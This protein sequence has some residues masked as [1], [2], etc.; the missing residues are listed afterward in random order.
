MTKR[1]SIW[2]ALSVLALVGL[3]ACGKSEEKKNDVAT[4]PIQPNCAAGTSLVYVNGYPMCQSPTGGYTTPIYQNPIVNGYNYSSD[5]YCYR[6]IQITNSTVAKKFLKE[7][8]GVCD[9]NHSTGGT[10]DCQAWANG[11]FKVNMS[12][13]G[14]QQMVTTIYAY[15]QQTGYWYSLPSFSDFFW[16]MLGF[17]VYNVNSYATRNPLSIPMQKFS[18]N[19]SLG[20]EGRGNGD[21]Y[22][23]ANRSLIQIQIPQGK[24]GDTHFT[25]YVGY[26]GEIF[27]T[28]TLVN[29]ATY[30]FYC[31]Y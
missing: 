27:M 1:Y 30:S 18:V 25:Y 20:F 6:D 7:A 21:F 12:T 9:Q 19:N 24:P 23:L 26:A 17:P 4:V 2:S 28:G 8:L 29:S 31:G 14:N 10:A 3:I 13:D 15:P 22:T 5:T 16:G 11:H